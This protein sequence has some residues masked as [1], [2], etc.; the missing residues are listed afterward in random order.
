M[1]MHMQPRDLVVFVGVCF[2]WALNVVASKY[3][4]D[5]LA[6]PPLLYAAARSILVMLALS[7]WL[8]PV[9][10]PLGRLVVAVF[11][12]GSGGFALMFIALQT[13]DPSTAGIIS[14]LSAPLTAILGII[15]LGERV[16]WR[17]GTGIALAFVGVTMALWS[18]TGL[19]LTTGVILVAVSCLV[20]A[21]GAILL[22]QLPEA[23]PLRLQA[24][25]GVTG[26]V[27]LTPLSAGFEWN[28]IPDGNYG[29]EALGILAFA[30]LVVS[31]GAHTIYFRMLQKYEANLV[32]P[33]TLMTPIF[34]VSLGVALTGD[35]V[36][37]LM[38]VGGVLAL[39]GVFV[40]AVRP[41]AK[42]PKA[43]LLR[44]L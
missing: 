12:L 25:S 2:V 41:S 40:I 42:L 9:P 32:A 44:K 8:L 10:R 27:V 6:V 14:L 28:A 36:T 20:G 17:R 21:V 31:V 26:F 18:P 34:T 35:S 11:M 37:P 39:L 16:H 7:P 1:H 19:I 43:F 30:A 13:T 22:K 5:H 29:W 23:N 15:F 3:V 38:I 24:W 33:L 4:V